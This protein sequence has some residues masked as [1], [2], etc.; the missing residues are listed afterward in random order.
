MALWLVCVVV[1]SA[2]EVVVIFIFTNV[3][4]TLL[5]ISN[6]SLEN[7]VEKKVYKNRLF[8]SLLLPG[9]L[10]Q[11]SFHL[12]TTQS[13][14]EQTFLFFSFSSLCNSIFFF[15]QSDLKVF[16]NSRFKSIFSSSGRR[17]FYF[18]FILFFLVLTRPDFVK[19]KTLQTDVK[20]SFHHSQNTH[21]R[22]IVK[23]NFVQIFHSHFQFQLTRLLT[24]SLFLNI[25]VYFWEKNKFSE[26]IFFML[27][28][29]LNL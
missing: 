25:K 5:Y 14:N 8:F 29:M 12:I 3:A 11:T 17:I 15:L 20:M 9:F 27:W 13:H 26:R 28:F 7:W 10:C 19:W 21:S 22:K 4:Y 1:C 2:V 23:E 16:L 18:F 24:S 6:F